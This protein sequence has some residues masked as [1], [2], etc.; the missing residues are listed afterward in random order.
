MLYLNYN[1]KFN[2]LIQK[3]FIVCCTFIMVLPHCK[4][5]GVANPNSIA[6]SDTLD[7]GISDLEAFKTIPQSSIY[8]VTVIRGDKREKQMVF[9]N[10]CPPYENGFMNM[11]EKDKFPL[12]IFKGRSISW[13]NFSFS[14]TVTIEIKIIDQNKVAINGPVKVLPSRYGITPNVDGNLIRFVLTK[15]GQC[16]VEIG[17]DGFKNGLMLFANPSE[18]DIPDSTSFQFAVFKQATTQQINK[19]PSQYSGIYFKKGVHNIEGFNVPNHIKN[20]YFEEGSWVYGAIKLDGNSNVKIYGRGVLSSAKLNYRESHC[21]EAIN[22]SDNIHLEGI[23]IADPKYFAVRLIGKNNKVNWIKIIGGWV[24]NCDGISAFEGSTV[25]NCFIWANDDNIKVYRDNIQFSDIV[26]WQLNNG[27]I[28]QLSWGNANASNVSIKRVDILHAEWNKG[29]VNRGVISCVGDKFGQG[30]M[31]GLQKDFIIEDLKTET[32]VSLIFR[33]SPNPASPNILKGMLFKDWDVK[34]DTSTKFRNYL[35]GS[36][37]S[38]KF[39]GLIFNNFIFNGTKFNS[40]NWFSL[41]KFDTA[42]IEPPL[43]Y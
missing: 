40:S 37:S 16:S 22:Q 32:P 8:E 31:N 19:I 5:K 23:V 14:G 34:M 7:L 2:S 1:H 9:Q 3:I 25:S 43:F 35:I 41:G 36:S 18:T 27:G 21:I 10:S 12:E 42:N 15:P 17:E 11:A 20:I 30:G 6:Y 26:C 4:K 28:I 29:E 13:S 38:E 33:I 24:Y 39:S